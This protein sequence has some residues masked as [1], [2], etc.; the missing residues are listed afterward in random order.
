MTALPTIRSSIADTARHPLSDGRRAAG[1]ATTEEAPGHASSVPLTIA[2]QV[3]RAA[4]EAAAIG[5]FVLAVL[6]W[7]SVLTGR[8]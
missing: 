3:A 8:V 4:L 1:R 7:A 2:G 6:V 5:S